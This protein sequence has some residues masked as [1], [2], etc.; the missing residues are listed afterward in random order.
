MGHVV[1]CRRKSVSHRKR[2]APSA[3]GANPVIRFANGPVAGTLV[4]GA[5]N[6]PAGL[7]QAITL[8][9]SRNSPTVSPERGPKSRVW[10]MA[11][12]QKFRLENG[13]VPPFVSG[14][15]RGTPV[16]MNKIILRSPEGKIKGVALGFD[17]LYFIIGPVVDLFTLNI[18]RYFALICVYALAALPW[19]LSG[20]K[21]AASVLLVVHLGLSFIRGKMVLR[22]YLKKGYVIESCPEQWRSEIE[23]M[24]PK[25]I[26]ESLSEP[27]KSQSAIRAYAVDAASNS[28]AS[29]GVEA[30]NSEPKKMKFNREFVLSINWRAVSEDAESRAMSDMRLASYFEDVE[31]FTV[32]IDYCYREDKDPSSR[33]LIQF[34]GVVI[35]TDGKVADD[36][37]VETV[38]DYVL[39]SYVMPAFQKHVESLGYDW[40]EFYEDWLNV[41]PGPPGAGFNVNFENDIVVNPWK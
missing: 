36:D 31:N 1:R 21:L 7:P 17:I 13:C 37:I 30:R 39:D 40:S 18:T 9:P 25:A 32:E 22:G 12:R 28:A 5:R 19:G 8:K 35:S 3:A 4:V 2:A 14:L 15:A 34:L 26:G 24:A 6:L 16:S 38:N 23:K 11:R 33:D 29:T 10:S 20:N 27:P 41:F